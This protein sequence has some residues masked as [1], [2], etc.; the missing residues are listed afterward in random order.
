ML[1]KTHVNSLFSAFFYIVKTAKIKH[2]SWHVHF[3][4]AGS[5]RH[6]A[7]NERTGRNNFPPQSCKI[8]KSSFICKTTNPLVSD[9][10]WHSWS[11][12]CLK[13]INL[14]HFLVRCVNLGF[15]VFHFSLNTLS[16]NHPSCCQAGGNSW[17]LSSATLGIHFTIMAWKAGTDSLC[18]ALI[19]QGSHIAAVYKTSSFFSSGG[20]DSTSLLKS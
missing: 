16:K 13:P 7:K 19:K 11:I 4:H 5:F 9:S 2:V 20:S 6:Y 3:S 8:P 12:C 17:T 10:F 1:K 18:M 14:V 15:Y